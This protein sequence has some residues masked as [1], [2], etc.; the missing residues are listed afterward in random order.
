MARSLFDTG[1]YSVLTSGSAIGSGWLLNF[2]TA[3]TATRT[4]TYNAPTAGSANANPVVADASGRFD[5]IWATQGETIKWVLTDAA[6]V[7]K[8]TVD[9]YPVTADPPTIAAA[10]DAFLA[11]SAALPI[12]NGGT[13]QTSAVNAL[14]ALL[15]LPLAG[16]TV[17]GNIIRTTKGVH[18][19]FNAAGMTGG[20][21]YAQAAGA[22]PTS[23]AGDIVF[24]W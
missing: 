8:V 5:E 21:L 24:E 12:A 13:G 10:L 7:V 3:G 1:I 19:Y 15:G 23:T 17:T 2:Y 4:T 6:G 11:A 9:N 14:A 20:R 18:P 22:D 16:G